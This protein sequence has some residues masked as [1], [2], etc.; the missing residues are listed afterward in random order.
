MTDFITVKK[1]YLDILKQ[2]MIEHILINNNHSSIL[3]N[4]DT[5]TKYIDGKFINKQC[6]RRKDWSYDWIENVKIEDIDLDYFNTDY[7][8]KL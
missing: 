3:H 6:V 2:S 5:M 4:D 8:R 1:K 7:T